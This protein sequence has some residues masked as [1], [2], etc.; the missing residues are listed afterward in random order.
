M[1]TD[2]V[3][4]RSRNLDRLRLRGVPTILPSVGAVRLLPISENPGRIN[5]YSPSS[6][7]PDVLDDGPFEGLADK[8]PFLCSRF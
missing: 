5:V 1:T 8:Y 3:P 2:A 6:M 7:L 4:R